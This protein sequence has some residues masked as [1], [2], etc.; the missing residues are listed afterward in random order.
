[1]RLFYHQKCFYLNL[2][3]FKFLKEEHSKRLSLE[4]ISHHLASQHFLRSK[5]REVDRTVT[6]LTV[7]SE[8]PQLIILPQLPVFP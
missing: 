6:K 8:R 7:Y 1:M 2:S 3:F 4:T 5:V